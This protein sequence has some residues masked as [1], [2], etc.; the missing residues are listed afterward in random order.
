MVITANKKSNETRTISKEVGT[1][2]IS[3]GLQKLQDFYNL[4]VED[5]MLKFHSEVLEEKKKQK[6]GYKW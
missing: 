6:E 4:A 1:R 3:T 5:K 2:D